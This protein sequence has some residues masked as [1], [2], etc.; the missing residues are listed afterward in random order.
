MAKVKAG[1]QQNHHH[2][3]HHHSAAEDLAKVPSSGAWII[4]LT[5]LANFSLATVKLVSSWVFKSKALEADA[6]HSFTD[7]AADV[8]AL[9]AVVVGAYLKSSNMKQTSIKRAESLLALI[10]SSVLVA[11][12]CHLL[13]DSVTILRTQATGT[14]PSGHAE[15][16]LPSIQAIWPAALTLVVKEGLYRTGEYYTLI[17]SCECC[18]HNFTQPS[19]SP[20]RSSLPS[21]HQMLPTSAPTAC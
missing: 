11:A 19:K 18:A 20:M 17:Q 7:L 4:Q 12:G 1:K 8:L 15:L 13:W 14:H 6:W 21:L 5:L 9:L 10:T 2:H 3:H 16:G